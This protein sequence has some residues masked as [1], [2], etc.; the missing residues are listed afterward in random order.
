MMSDTILTVKDMSMVFGG[1]RAVDR[2]N[3]E[4]RQGEIVALIGP[5]GS[6]KTT[7]FNCLTGI[8]NPTEGEVTALP[9]AGKS[10]VLNGLKPNIINELG[11]ARTFQNIRLF[12]KMSVLENVLIGRHQA[13]A[14]G[15]WG[16]I[17]RNTRT[18]EEEEKGVHDSYEILKKIKLEKYVNDL[19]ENLPYGAQRRLEIARAIATD[20]FLLLLDEPA[21]GMNPHETRELVDMIN[22]I[23]DHEKITILLIEHDMSLVMT[24]SERIYV[25]DYG[26]LIAEGVPED[27]KRNPAVIKAYLGE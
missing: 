26:K 18:R 6:G 24:L 1:L 16:A 22:W 15:V 21:A 11:L 9:P 14:A 2:M 20:P 27:I 3:V 17:A 4:I 7:F 23:R 5:N 25:M 19:A 10:R 13:L 8:Y 12:N